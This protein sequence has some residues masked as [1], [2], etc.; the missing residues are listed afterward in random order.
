VTG[1]LEGAL[2]LALLLTANSAQAMTVLALASIPEILSTA[3]WFTAMQ[4]RL[5]PQRQ[6][7][8]FSLAAPLWDCGSH[9]G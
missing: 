2:H 9:W 4:Q 1:I 6:G 5:T 7:V 8:F 3:T